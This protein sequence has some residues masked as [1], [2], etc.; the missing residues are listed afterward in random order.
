MAMVQDHLNA[1]KPPTSQPDGK[2]GK[3][4]NTRDLDVDSKKEEPSF[5]QTFFSTAK[6]GQ[7]K[8]SGSV[9]ETVGNLLAR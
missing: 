5:F 3:I 4:S 2:S 6:K 1:R 8:K 9:M 7:P